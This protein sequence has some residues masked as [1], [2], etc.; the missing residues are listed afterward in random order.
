MKIGLFVVRCSF[1][2]RCMIQSFRSSGERGREGVGGKRDGHHFDDSPT[3]L[4]LASGI[5]ATILLE[6]GLLTTTT[7][8]D[9]DD[10][11]T[12][13]ILM[14]IFFIIVIIIFHLTTVFD[15]E[16]KLSLSLSLSLEKTFEG[17]DNP[18]TFHN[19]QPL[20]THTREKWDNR[21]WTMNNG[22]MGQC[23][24]C[25]NVQ[26]RQNRFFPYTPKNPKRN[27]PQSVWKIY[28]ARPTSTSMKIRSSPL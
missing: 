4:G 24:M 5:L 20:F 11:V 19:N 28:L 10:D 1:P 14:V 13:M 23:V 18:W 16:K 6:G 27:H 17:N 3:W 15:E 9:D 21:Q 26:T 22:T 2:R 12:K 8:Y 25:Q 7:T